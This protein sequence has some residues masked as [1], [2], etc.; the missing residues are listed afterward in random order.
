M[1]TGTLPVCP[2]HVSGCCP[3]WEIGTLIAGLK[4]M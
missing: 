3:G 2:Y 1:T 4:P